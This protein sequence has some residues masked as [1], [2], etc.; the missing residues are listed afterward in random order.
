METNKQT[1]TFE[2]VLLDAIRTSEMDLH[3][4]MPAKVTAVDN[5]LQ[6]VSL[7][8]MLK[9][10]YKINGT[11]E[12]TER[13][14]IENLP[15]KYMSGRG[16]KS[17]VHVP[18][19]VGDLGMVVFCDRSL[20][21]YLSG[22]GENTN[23]PND[24]R[25]HDISDGYFLAGVNPWGNAISGVSDENITIKNSDGVADSMTITIKPDG[26]MTFQG[27]TQ[28]MM[29]VLSG[30]MGHVKDLTT[31]L[32]TLTTN[33]NSATVVTA[34]GASPFTAA[35]LALLA[36]DLAAITADEILLTTDKTNFDT[37]KG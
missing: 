24:T 34:L 3:V 37:L 31:H 32:K 22:D 27:T 18:V 2:Q 4:S 6:K 36:T 10:K 11:T 25:L 7:L 26:T 30:F 23:L 19:A 21:V 29:A 1:P 35:T 13:A 9:K 8:P 16:G 14:I 33:L 28:E 20:D 12:G 5:S 15:I 17:F